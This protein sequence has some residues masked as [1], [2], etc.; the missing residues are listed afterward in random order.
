[1]IVS[2]GHQL[3]L[4]L[5]N[6]TGGEVIELA[7]GDYGDFYLGRRDFS[8][9]VTIKSADASNPALEDQITI[10]CK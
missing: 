6:A 3:S 8:S 7:A 2:N 9:E 10:D 5:A 4:A 1:M